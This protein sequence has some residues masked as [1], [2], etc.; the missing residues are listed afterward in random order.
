MLRR[1]LKAACSSAVW[2]FDACLDAL[3][4]V[5]AGRP[6][7]IGTVL[8]FH[9]VLAD[10]R[11]K[12]ADMLDRLGR[13]AEIVP[14]NSPGPFTER[15]YYVA[16]TFDDAFTSVLQNAVPELAARQIPFAIFVPAGLMGTAPAW[17]RPGSRSHG[18]ERVMHAQELAALDPALVTIGSHGVAHRPLAGL[19]A[20]E[21]DEDLRES[22]RLLESHLARAVTLFSFPYGSYDDASVRS[23]RAAG[24]ERV[25]TSSPQRAFGI[26][27]EFLVGRT[28]ADPSDWRWEFFLKARGAYRWLPWGWKLNRR[29]GRILPP[30]RCGHGA[31]RTAPHAGEGAA[32]TRPGSGDSSAPPARKAPGDR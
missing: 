12:F 7:S 32:D 13:W 18:R 8:Y 29:V 31:R 26:R 30:R 10:E 3:S 21:T 22:R 1:V 28:A 17:L 11:G 20:E 25:F 14:L 5:I 6:R 19:S 2:L 9:S 16:V 24:Y 4:R 23:A 15:S 27:E